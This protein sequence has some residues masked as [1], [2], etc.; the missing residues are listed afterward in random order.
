MHYNIMISIQRFFQNFKEWQFI[1]ITVF[2]VV[3]S[4]FSVKYIIASAFKK[5]GNKT[6]YAV[7]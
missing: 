2:T 6:L 4:V 1:F 3:K 5:Q 7:V